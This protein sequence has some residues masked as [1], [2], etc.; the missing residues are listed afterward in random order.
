MDR[1]RSR[2]RSV[3]HPY[4]LP[5]PIFPADNAQ[6]PPTGVSRHLVWNGTSTL[7]QLRR[8]LIL[9]NLQRSSSCYG[10]ALPFGCDAS[11][12]DLHPS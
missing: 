11:Y 9:V 10:R 4:N 1:S 5:A 2:T 12:Q 7:R 8:V 3:E 6:A